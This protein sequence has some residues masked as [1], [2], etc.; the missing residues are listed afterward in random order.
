MQRRLIFRKPGDSQIFVDEARLA[1][2]DE[3][4]ART[5]YL[6]GVKM[7]N[8]FNMLRPN[9]L[10]WNYVVNNYMQRALSPWRSDL[11][12]WNS[13]STRIPRANQHSFYLRG[14]YLENRL[15]RGEMVIDGV[16]LNSR[17]VKSPSSKSR[18]RKIT[19]RRRARYFAARNFSA[20]M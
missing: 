18:R 9:E 16:R 10:I 2:L 19:L 11:L 3:S 20:A 12:Y 14:C 1:S 15:A 17:Q 8:A 7:A 4:M 13:D 6:E 5:G